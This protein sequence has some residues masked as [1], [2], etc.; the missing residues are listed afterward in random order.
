MLQ[1][2]FRK[3]PANDNFAVDA[4]IQEAYRAVLGREADDDGLVHFRKAIASGTLTPITLL[5]NLRNS[6]ENQRHGLRLSSPLNCIHEARKRMVRMLPSVDTIVDL[7]GA[8]QG[9]DAG[10]MILMGYPYN[11][12]T[13]TIVEAPRDQRHDIY[14][15]VCLTDS[16]TSVDTGRGM[17]HYLFRSMGDLQP[18][19]DA[20]VDMV[21][22]GESIEH[23]TRDE[24]ERV[25]QEAW[26]VLKPGGQFCLDTPN[27]DITRIQVPDGFINPDHKWEYTHA[28]MKE[29]INRHHFTIQ[30]Q[31]GLIWMPQTARER[32]FKAEE[33][34]LNVGIY[35]DIERCYL[36]YY[37]CVKN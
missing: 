36:L 13:L 11:F 32:Q 1:T 2:L 12:K 37:R 35:D 19:P 26:R 10:A 23:V 27:R 29:I 8:A 17:V 16:V 3:R 6:E 24:C 9:F 22:S 34:I 31:K 14:K 18:I 21:F 5:E 7:G 25:F 15:N 33:L 28:E 30:E 4:F 20:S